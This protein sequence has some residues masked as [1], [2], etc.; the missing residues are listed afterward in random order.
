MSEIWKRII[1]WFA[2]NVPA[3]H[4]KFAEGASNEEIEK[5]EARMRLHFPDDLRESY[6]LHNGMDMTTLSWIAIIYY[7]LM[8]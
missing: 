2:A 6:L 1:A 7:R 3:K 5:A 4:Y 8:E